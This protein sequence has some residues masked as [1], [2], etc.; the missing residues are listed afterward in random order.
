MTSQELLGYLEDSEWWE[1][2]G[3]IWIT[4]DEDG[5]FDEDASVE[6]DLNEVTVSWSDRGEFLMKTYPLNDIDER[7]LYDLQ[8]ET[9]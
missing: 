1:Q 4:V 8:L 9:E 7:V 2:E 5:E 6:F 3:D